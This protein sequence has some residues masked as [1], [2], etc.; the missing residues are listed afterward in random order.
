MRKYLALAAAAGATLSLAA[1]GGSMHAQTKTVTVADKSGAPP[2][3][4]TT[5]KTTTSTTSTD[6]SSSSSAADLTGPVGTAYSDTDDSNNVMSVK[7]TQIIDPAKGANE[8]ETPDNGK[9]FVGAKF[10][11]TGTSGSFNDDANSDA[12]LVGSDG[13]SYTA[14]FDDIAGCT[15]FN[16]GDFTVTPHQTSVGCVVFEV[17]D[18]VHVRS[19]QWNSSLEGTPATWTVE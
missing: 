6:D 17:P 15:N 16:G 7:L 14:D 5:P 13:Q 4:A 9:R 12:T 8:F 10:K 2:A 19:V 18:S 3:T 11:L 1:C